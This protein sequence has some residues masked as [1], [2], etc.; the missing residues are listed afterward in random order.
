VST[1]DAALAAVDT[2][3]AATA[4]AAA[5]P[6][7][8]PLA[9]RPPG[10]DAAS[11][12]EVEER[13]V[14]AAAAAAASTPASALPSRL[15]PAALQRADTSDSMDSA[16]SRSDSVWSSTQELEPVETL[17]EHAETATQEVFEVRAHRDCYLAVLCPVSGCGSRGDASFDLF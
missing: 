7:P 6:P 15:Q 17:F 14:A 16:V 5:E 3:A 9:A 4:A 11:Q 8:P 1:C 2:A 13:A 12:T 10:V